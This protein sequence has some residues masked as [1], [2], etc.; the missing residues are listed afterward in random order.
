M[1]VACSGPSSN[2]S[3]R[4]RCSS[5]WS[6]S[7]S[8]TRPTRCETTHGP[9]RRFSLRDPAARDALRRVAHQSLSCRCAAQLS[10]GTGDGGVRRVRQQHGGRGRLPVP[11]S[12][13]H[14]RRVLRSEEH[15]SELQSLAY[16]VCRLLLEKKKNRNRTT[17]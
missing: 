2:T 7:T 16:L 1:S 4:V 15:T 5:A 17:A 13:A 10:T 8:R 9:A 6:A 3:S 14:R 11:A 12:H